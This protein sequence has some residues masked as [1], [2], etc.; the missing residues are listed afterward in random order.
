MLTFCFIKYF[1]CEL[2]YVLYFVLKCLANCLRALIPWCFK[3]TNLDHYIINANWR[4]D[5]YLWIITTFRG[6]VKS[7]MCL[8]LGVEQKWIYHC[9]CLMSSIN[10]PLPIKS[11]EVLVAYCRYILTFGISKL[12]TCLSYLSLAVHIIQSFT[13]ELTRFLELR[14]VLIYSFSTF[15]IICRSIYSGIRFYIYKLEFYNIPLN[16]WVYRFM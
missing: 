13:F 2:F 4:N 16:E 14:N 15:I 5:I 7:E 10:T 1:T 11:G 9:K 6:V 8:L 3:N 12:F